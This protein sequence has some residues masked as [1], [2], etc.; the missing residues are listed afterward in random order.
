MSTVTRAL[1]AFARG[2]VSL[3]QDLAAAPAAGRGRFSVAGPA[4]G[5]ASLSADLGGRP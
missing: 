3:V 5:R 1:R 2:A 4:G